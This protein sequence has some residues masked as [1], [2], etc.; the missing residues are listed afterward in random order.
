LLIVFADNT[1]PFWNLQLF[2]PAESHVKVNMTHKAAVSNKSPNRA[3]YFKQ[4]EILCKLRMCYTCNII[5]SCR[6]T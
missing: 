4:K 3:L 5:I 2:K 1:L 6:P